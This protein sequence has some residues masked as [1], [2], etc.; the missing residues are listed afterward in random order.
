ELEHVL[1]QRE[2]SGVAGLRR[3]TRGRTRDQL[4]RGGETVSGS[5]PSEARSGIR[6]ERAVARVPDE[7][8]RAGDAGGARPPRAGRRSRLESTTPRAR[9]RPP[10]APLRPG[11][12][13]LR[14]KSRAAD[15]HL[16]RR[17]GLSAPPS[18]WSLDGGAP[19]GAIERDHEVSV[20]PVGV[21]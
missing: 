21:P 5:D 7:P 17:P 12:S 20:A 11:R 16:V 3:R 1:S 18:R 14:R 6:A 19:S 2:L 13:G 4:A 10:E 15:D 9:D 8:A